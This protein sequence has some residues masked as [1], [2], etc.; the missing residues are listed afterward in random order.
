M[1]VNARE[2]LYVIIELTAEDIQDIL[3]GVDVVQ[4]STA[5]DDQNVLVRVYCS[6]PE[7]FRIRK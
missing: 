2:K 1:I 7:D 6:N 5:A 4:E 3:S